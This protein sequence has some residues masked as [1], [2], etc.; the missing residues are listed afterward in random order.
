MTTNERDWESL[1]SEWRAQSEEVPPA[2]L[3]RLIVLERR[4]T[5]AVIAG[6]AVTIGGFAWLS[7]LAAKDGLAPWETVW[8][9]TLWLFTAVVVPFA[10]WNRRG[11]WSAFVESVA[12]FER[13]RDQRRRRTLRFA[14]ALFSAEA[15]VV[16]AELAWF[17]RL[18][19]RPLLILLGFAVVFAAWA[20]WMRRSRDT[21]PRT[22]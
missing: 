10:W 1:A 6:E 11:I 22:D 8:I 21:A 4:R 9:S 12:E 14:C 15:I 3:H 17:D 19:A 5:L 2:T 20:F 13:R 18:T 7:W 16:I